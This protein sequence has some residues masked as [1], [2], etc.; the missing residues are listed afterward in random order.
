MERLAFILKSIKNRTGIEVSAFSEDMSIVLTEQNKPISL[1][2]KTDFPQIYH[3]EKQ[4]RTFFKFRFSDVNFI[5]SLIGV[6]KQAENYACLIASLIENYSEDIDYQDVK[7]NVKRIVLGHISSRNVE[8]FLAEN[9]IIDGECFCL[10]I[11]MDR[12][13]SSQASAFIEK[14]AASNN[15]LFAF[16]DKNTCAYIKTSAE[17]EDKVSKEEFAVKLFEEVYKKTGEKVL[18]GVGMYKPKLYKADVSFKEA[19]SAMKMN[20]FLYN[21][22]SV[23]SYTDFVL[24]RLLEDLP[25]YKLKEVKD[26]LLGEDADSIFCDEEMLRTA[27]V[28]ME[29]DLNIS[30]ASRELYM[31]RNTL[32]YRLDKIKRETNLDIR[33]FSDAVIFRI[34][35]IIKKITD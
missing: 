20:G 35:S 32:T 26:I 29:N 12:L 19:L 6:D 34:L 13:L 17:G 16:I 5:G 22:S 3:S 28:L 10:A 8:R 31:H 21:N 14:T 27:G 25:K 7:E 11:T 23:H 15:D 9:S 24:I 1:P 33:K 30:E 2:D 18:I 4:N